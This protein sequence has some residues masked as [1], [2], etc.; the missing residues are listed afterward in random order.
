[1]RSLSLTLVLFAA[2][3]ALGA[4]GTSQ[5]VKPLAFSPEGNGTIA[6]KF[7]VGPAVIMGKDLKSQVPDPS[8]DAQEFAEEVRQSVTDQ[9][10]K[11]GLLAGSGEA[12]DQLRFSVCY[13][14]GGVLRGFACNPAASGL[15]L[16]SPKD[17]RAETSIWHDGRLVGR[18]QP[19]S[20]T[21]P[22]LSDKKL[23][24]D[25]YAKEVVE[26]IGALAKR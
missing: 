7:S 5:G 1:M 9:L 12:G 25:R 24:A 22:S 10:A 8:A 16:V 6:G 11:A 15:F 18:L 23:L 3:L 14:G 21:L 13:S 17:Y 20:G 2:A 4:C 19:A 26:S